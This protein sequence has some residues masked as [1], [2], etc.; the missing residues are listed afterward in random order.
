MSELLESRFCERKPVALSSCPALEHIFEPLCS[1]P[2]I[3]RLP[4][5]KLKVQE[6]FLYLGRLEPGGK[7][8]MQYG[9]RQ[10]EL[11]REI[12]QLLTEDLTRRFTIEE[13]SHRYLT[14]TSTLKE[15]F[16][17]VYGLPIAAYMKEYRIRRSM[18]LLR[19][20]PS[21]IAAIA[22]QVG[23]ETQGKFSKAFKDVTGILP[24]EYRKTCHSN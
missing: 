6:L 14:N 4:L 5:L 12:H 23:Y 3:H 20:T 9:S 11:I 19:E 21:T 15:V 8:L 16:K 10:T 18:E 2:S 22:A 7:E 1:V 17:A 24:T 13:L